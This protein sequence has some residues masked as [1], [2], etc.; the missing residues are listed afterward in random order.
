MPTLNS[1]PGRVRRTVN[2]LV[3]AE[4]LLVQAAI[5]SATA[6][7]EGLNALGKHLS[8][9]EDQEAQESFSNTLQRIADAALEPYSCRFKVLR[10]MIR[11]SNG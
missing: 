11:S 1:S 5:E 10:N 2:D 3:V 7:G 9:R 6:I 8:G 4:M